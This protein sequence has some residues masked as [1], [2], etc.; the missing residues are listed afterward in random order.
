[1]RVVIPF[2]LAILL[3]TGACH[4]TSAPSAVQQ[5]YEN[6]ADA[7]DR[8]A[9]QQPTPQAKKIYRA[10]ADAVRDEGEDRKQGL[11]KSGTKVVPP[12]PA[13]DGGR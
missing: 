5:S 2:A 8:Q 11:E 10:R 13:V 6:H 4:D 3:L 12:M 7:I 9:E 1:M